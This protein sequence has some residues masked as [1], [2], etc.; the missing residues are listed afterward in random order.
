MFARS[1]PLDSVQHRDLRVFESND[2]RYAKGELI[3]PIVFDEIADAAREY[4][5][6]FPDNKSDLPCV[7]MG[8]ELNENA[9]VAEDGRWQARYVPAHIR[10][11]PFVLGTMPPA[12]GQSEDAQRFAVMF[13]PDAPH[14]M[15]PNGYAIFD[16]NGQFTEHMQM[17]VGMLERM[18]KSVPVTQR[19]VRAIGDAGL[20]VERTFRIKRGND[21]RQVTG[22]RVIDE[23][24][25]NT[26]P[27]AD[28]VALR[29]TGALPLIYAQLLS[30]ANFRQGPLAGKYPDLTRPSPA[31]NEPMAYMDQEILRF[32]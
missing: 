17:R 3:A 16:Q 4:P 30:W 8:L 15:N 26:M 23:R 19:L 11:Y 1:V 28:F 6:V 27:D 21:E 14:F 25:L 24:K 13:D 29:N 32:N 5:I 20:L 31:A 18:Q 22:T 9:Y 7:L 10:R 2:Y 12:E